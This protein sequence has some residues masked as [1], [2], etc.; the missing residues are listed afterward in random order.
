MFQVTKRDGE[1]AEFTLGKIKN[2]IIKAFDATS[3]QYSED[4]VD[5][6]SLRV[7]AKFQEKVKDGQI[8]V[9]DNDHPAQYP[10]SIDKSW[11]WISAFLCAWAISSS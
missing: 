1:T 8:H 10:V 2:A 9:E 11:I 5:L 6:L 4:I 7:T 3:V